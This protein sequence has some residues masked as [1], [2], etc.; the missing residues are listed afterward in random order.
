MTIT[1]RAAAKF[2][3]HLGVGPVREDGYHPLATVYQAIGLYDDV[4]A[5]ESDAWDVE[6]TA[7]DHIA[8]GE[9]PSGDDNIVIRAGKLLAA[10]H[11][12][13]RAA[14]IAIHKGIP[15]A[16]GLAGGSADAAATLVALDRLWSLE[17]PDEE[18]LSLAG[19][20]GSDVP[21]ALIGATA[22]GGGRGELVEP[23]TDN[24]DWWW[25]VVGNEQGLSTPAVYRAFDEHAGADVADPEVPERLLI[26][27]EKGDPELLAAALDNDLQTP[28]LALRPDLAQTFADG[29]EAGA[30]AVQLSG[31]GPT[32]LMLCRDAPHAR[33]VA[34]ALQ[35]KSYD[36]V[37]T[38]PAPVA[39]AHVL[40]Y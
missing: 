12:I 30:L 23:L 38:A 6:L 34:G 35:A 11:G 13:D 15:V 19:Q 10:H 2:N 31:S 5:G 25:V 4:T 29:E 14:K 36:R 24:G 33:E 39:G 9:I 17:T 16:G 8:L 28:A 40:T 1:V 20:L 37:W 22:V 26:A 7:E 21:F 27:L 18:L 3:L 32:V